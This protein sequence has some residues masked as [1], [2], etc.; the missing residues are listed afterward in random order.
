MVS[1][2]SK[3][4]ILERQLTSEF[5]AFMLV[6]F[7]FLSGAI[8][9]GCNILLTAITGNTHYELTCA[10]GFSA[11]IFAIKVVLQDQESAHQRQYVF[12]IPIPIRMMYWSELFIIQLVAPQSSFIGHLSGILVGLLYTK[13]PLKP[14]MM[15]IFP[16]S[17]RQNEG[18]EEQPQPEYAPDYGPGYGPR[19]YGAPGFGGFGFRPFGP[20]MG[21]SAYRR[22]PSGY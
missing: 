13:G 7:T 1:F 9:V 20:R 17:E 6:V 3:G 8:L 15:A 19:N 12:G 2:L 5:F 16:P 10:I 11:V 21:P 22:Y 18:P 4:F 14:L